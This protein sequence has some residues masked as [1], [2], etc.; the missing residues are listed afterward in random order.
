MKS[1]LKKIDES[2][3][4][5]AELSY[6]SIGVGLEAGYAKAKGKKIIYIHQAGTELSTTVNGISDVRIKYNN[7]SDLLTQLKNNKFSALLKPFPYTL[8]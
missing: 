5:I 3:L 2:N 4:L 7:I 8:N 1:A 6:K